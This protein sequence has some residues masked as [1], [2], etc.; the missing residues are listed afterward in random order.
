MTRR[1][2]G[3][4]GV[5]GAYGGAAVNEAFFARLGAAA[6]AWTGK[7]G[8]VLIGRDTRFSGPALAEAL[9]LGLRAGGLEPQSLGVLPTP[10]VARAVREAGAVLGAVVTASHNP[11]ADNGVKFFRGDGRKLTDEDEARI[12]AL[13]PAE[14]PAGKGAALPENRGGLKAYVTAVSRLLPAGALGGWKVVL[15]T[16][17][18]ATVETSPRIL[19]AFGAE[20]TAIGEDPDGKNINA[21]VGSE[22]P[23]A[24]AARVVAVGARLGI[25][26]DGD[27]DRC[28]LCDE[29][30]GVL[31][32]DE[33]LTLLA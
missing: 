24:L 8:A 27:G 20:L 32:G 6:A 21:G 22:H 18:G 23:A 17:H 11:A 33:I 29:Q 12:E 26:H 25:A 10:A 4:D 31:D 3:T 1:Y 5:R 2:F 7:S 28:V 13:L 14:A 15:D 16:A 19:R 30:G 9:A